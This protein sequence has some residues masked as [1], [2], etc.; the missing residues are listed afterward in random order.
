MMRGNPQLQAIALLVRKFGTKIPGG[1]YEVEVTHKEMAEM[2]PHGTFQE[3]P[4]L[5]LH[6][7]RWQYFPN[8][9][10]E[11]VGGIVEDHGSITVEGKLTEEGVRVFGEVIKPDDESTS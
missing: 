2:S 8:N 10:I 9:T 1:G 7:V 11:G 5:D 4:E 3:I 6:K